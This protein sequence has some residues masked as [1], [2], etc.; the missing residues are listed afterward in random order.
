MTIAP[1]L[2]LL[3]EL[4]HRCP[5]RCVYCSNPLQLEPARAELNSDSW[6]RVLD[7]AADLGVFQVHFSG[8]EPL[9]RDDLAT[10]IA[11]AAG[12]GLYSNLITSGILLD[13]ERARRLA[14]AGLEHVQISVQD[15]D[16][17][18]T[19]RIGGLMGAC[20]QKKR[21]AVWIK[22][23][24][25]ALT[26]NTVI[27]RHNCGRVEE[28]IALA[29]ELGAGRLEVAHVQYYGWGLVNRAALIPTRE[30]LEETTRVVKAARERLAGVLV[31]DYVVPDYYARL[32]KACMGGWGQR[33][34]N[35]DPTGRV[36]PCHAA[37]TIPGLSF[38]TVHE[39]GL[40]DIWESS[41]AFQRFRGT[42]WMAEP[43]RDC[44]RRETDWGGCRCQALALTGNAA[45]ADP[46]CY[47]SPWHEQ[48]AAL[49]ATEAEE[50]APRFTYRGAGRGTGR[51][52]ASN[53]PPP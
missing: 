49:A 17:E 4:T 1:P 41:P 23:A 37:T 47:K 31:I 39:R 32:P 20:E 33:F 42:A 3:A 26:L 27:H 7:E 9:V 36:L 18:G 2:A 44:E 10:L 52:R 24:G 25:L 35:I 6:R 12:C 43:C 53:A 28:L 48:I 46:A 21:A 40:A 15:I 19:E 13:A 50:P 22:D 51:R 34:I 30:Q 5:M 45:N 11:H 29:V 8:G 38:E 14:D 16:R